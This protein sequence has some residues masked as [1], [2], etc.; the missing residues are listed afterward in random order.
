MRGSR[1]VC[2]ALALVLLF[3]ATGCSPKEEEV[4]AEYLLYFA[5]SRDVASGPALDTE[6]FDPAD[7]TTAHPEGES[8]PSPGDLV[9]AL[10]AGPQEEG[11][12]SPFPRGVTLVSWTWDEEQPG[13]LQIRLSEQY[14]GLTDIALTL[15]DYAIVLTLSQLEGVETVEIA[16]GG[17]AISYRSHQILSEEEA[18]LPGSGSEPAASF[19]RRV[20]ISREIENHWGK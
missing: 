9:Q 3:G 12:R 1:L 16:S 15:A 17:R 19:S 13:N 4:P 14:G 18:E 20:V 5:V 6:P 2:G 10:L 7:C 8:C 11:H